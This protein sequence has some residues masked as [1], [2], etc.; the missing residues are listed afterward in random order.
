MHP[1]ILSD[2]HW[3]SENIL[4]LL[5]NAVK[6]SEV[7]TIDLRITIVDNSEKWCNSSQLSMNQMVHVSVEDAGIGISEEKRYIHIFICMYIY[8][9]THHKLCQ[10]I[11]AFIY[12]CIHIYITGM[13]C[14]S[15]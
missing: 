9:Y 13:N 12:T 15:L 6:Y 8:I 1:T 11:C 5:S 4:C 14:S 10:Y 7:G 2:K 3:I